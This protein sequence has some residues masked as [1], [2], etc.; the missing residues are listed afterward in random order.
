MIEPQLTDIWEKNWEKNTEQNV[1][2]I[3]GNMLI[4][5]KFDNA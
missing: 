1:S 3:A 5:T 4:K 2:L